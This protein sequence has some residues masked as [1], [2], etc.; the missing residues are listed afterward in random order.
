[1]NVR[2]GVMKS[3]PVMLRI[4]TAVSRSRRMETDCAHQR[5]I[6]LHVGSDNE[7]RAQLTTGR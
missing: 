7:L 6:F 2:V 1:M 5:A 4:G 3:P